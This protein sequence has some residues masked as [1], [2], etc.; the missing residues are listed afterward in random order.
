[1]ELFDLELVGA[2][3]GPSLADGEAL[4]GQVRIRLG[5]RGLTA[6][7]DEAPVLDFLL[8]LAEGL[9]E[10]LRGRTARVAAPLADGHVLRLR[11]DAG[12]VLLTLAGC[13][14]VVVRDEAVEP[15]SLRAAVLHLGG[16]VA[17]MLRA[18]SGPDLELVEAALE[19]LAT[20][21][22][23]PLP[24][25]AAGAEDAV[26]RGA[27]A[28]RRP[29][30]FEFTVL[31]GPAI[32]LE[33]RCDDVVLRIGRTDPVQLA[34]TLVAAAETLLQTRDWPAGAHLF[35]LDAR[36]TRRLALRGSA[37]ALSAGVLD[38]GDHDLCPP[39]PLDH[40]A[41][42]RAVL[43]LLERLS[44]A[45]PADDALLA[46]RAE[47]RRLVGWARAL[48]A[49]D[50]QRAAPPPAGWEVIPAEERPACV[51]PLPVRGLQ[52]LAYRRSWRREAPGL[53]GVQAEPD[54]LYV[55]DDNGMSALDAA[56][57]AICWRLAGL[58]PLEQGPP[59]YALTASGAL[60]RV[61]LKAG[62]VR[63]RAAPG[64]E[65]EP[66]RRLQRVGDR[67][68]A[69]GSGSVVRGLDA[70]T[71]RRH[72]RYATH[73]GAVL[74]SRS[75]GPMLWLTA[76]DGFVHGID[77]NAGERRFAVRVRGEPEGAPCPT[78]HGLLIGTNLGPEPASELLVLD[79]LS[80]D[81][82]WQRAFDAALV[83][84]P[85]VV[86][87]HALVAVDDG[88][89]VSVCTVALADGAVRWR[90]TLAEPAYLPALSVLDDAV[91]VKGTDGRV[92]A[93]ELAD[94]R[95][96]WTLDADDPDE[97]LVVNAP[98]VLCRG[99]LLVPGTRIR[100][101]D[102]HDGRVVHVLD[103][104][105]LVP[106]WMHVWPDGDLA[107]AEDEAVARYLLG[108]HLALVA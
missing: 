106:R 103:C 82:R 104:G 98:L 21:P 81:R 57:G 77:V 20:A 5:E 88:L 33:V 37:A 61:D 24:A 105:E 17:A 47:S 50:R 100:A 13:G 27:G 49:G 99:V 38:P 31:A 28:G 75:H 19:G 55:F 93:L 29:L 4:V 40:G 66:P 51:G 69:C 22:E 74:A 12:R 91:Y 80:G 73:Y 92:T 56:T 102:P 41:F 78:P 11:A 83:A 16:R 46:L 94:G 42:V 97:A 43:H 36:G 25:S 71:G 26:A 52:H 10:L 72:W 60:A 86:G 44:A 39:V 64:P 76:E 15:G 8:P 85:V 107:I 45:L 101:L 23:A 53:A 79:P 95:V 87:G 65:G 70:V 2:V 35:P 84:G 67:L 14:Q 59:G 108:G 58:A 89:D 96:R 1:M 18:A 30:A 90:R 63:W 54:R 34:E 48:A 32:G 62:K 6:H 9:G 7:L 3:A 68:V